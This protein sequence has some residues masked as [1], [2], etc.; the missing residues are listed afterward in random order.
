MDLTTAFKIL[1]ITYNLSGKV[2]KDLLLD[3]VWK[4]LLQLLYLRMNMSARLAFKKQLYVLLII[5]GSSYHSMIT[6]MIKG[7]QDRL[8]SLIVSHLYTLSQ[9]TRSWAHGFSAHNDAV[10]LSGHIHTIK[11]WLIQLLLISLC[12]FPWVHQE[13]CPII[14]VFVELRISYPLTQSSNMVG[15]TMTVPHLLG[16]GGVSWKKSNC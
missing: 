12:V 13:T 4:I 9:A 11:S 15:N 14:G 10:P 7:W 16:A 2:N 8:Y 3:L 1:W 6:M 5:I